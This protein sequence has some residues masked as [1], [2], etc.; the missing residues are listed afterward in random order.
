MDKPTLIT[1]FFGDTINLR[2]AVYDA[3]NLPFLL[4][5]NNLN[6]AVLTVQGLGRTV[7]GTISANVVTFKFTEEAG[8]PVGKHNFYARVSGNKWPTDRYVIAH[9]TIIILALPGVS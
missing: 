8:L 4:T 5:T 3:Q 7:A 9:G 1:A 6:S 2:V